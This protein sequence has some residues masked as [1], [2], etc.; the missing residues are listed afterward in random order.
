MAKLRVYTDTGFGINFDADKWKVMDTNS[1]LIIT[2]D[3]VP[4]GVFNGHSWSQIEFPPE[5][6]S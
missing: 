6:E 5:D 2:K 1:L 3:D 4:V